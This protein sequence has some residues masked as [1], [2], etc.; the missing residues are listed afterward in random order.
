MKL[1]ALLTAALVALAVPEAALAD[2]TVT[3][4]FLYRDRNFTYNGGFNGIEPTRPVRQA[5]VQV[6][7][8]STGATLAAA[9]TDDTGFVSIDVTGSGQR[10]IL[11]RCQSR[12]RLYGSFRIRVE[13]TSQ[14]LYS[15]STGVFAGWDQNTDLDFGTVISEKIFSGSSQANPFNMLDMCVSGLDYVLAQGAP[16]PS[17]T[18]RMQWPGGSGSFASGF[19]AN[20]ATDDGYD[21]MVQLHEL[22]H[23]LHNMYSDSD[24]PGGSH[25]FGDS[26]QDP[27]LSYGEGWAT[28]FAGAV[29]NWRNIFD[30]AFYMDCNG[31]VAT[32]GIQLRMRMENSSPYISS[33]GGEA[34]EVGVACALWD[35]VDTAS[36]NDGNATDDDPLDGSFVFLNAADGDDMHWQTFTGPVD[37]AANLTIRNHWDAFFNPVDYG[38]HAELETIFANFGINN[39]LDADE[40]NNS[41]GGATPYVGNDTWTPIRTLYFSNATPPAPGAG[42]T[43]HYSFTLQNGEGFEVETRYPNGSSNALTYADPFLRIFR[44]NGTIFATNNDGGTGRNAFINATA[45]A[46]GTWVA[47]VSST[48]SYRRTGSYQLRIFRGGASVTGITPSTI[49]AVSLT[50]QEIVINGSGFNNTTGVTIDGVALAAGVSGEYQVE[51]DGQIRATVPLLTQ[52]G[53]VDVTVTTTTA[54]A[55][56]QIQVDPVSSPLVIAPLGAIQSTGITLTSAANLLDWTWVAVSI[57]NEPTIFPGLFALDIGDNNSQIVIP[58]RPVIGLP[59]HVTK[60]FGPL[61]GLAGIQLYWQSFVLE[62][63][64]MYDPP[65]PSSN[66]S[67]TFILF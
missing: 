9:P 17:G 56:A 39:F 25:V 28:F 53:M 8:N 24:S 55:T 60:T 58:W 20:M 35:L 51:S 15:V 61:S 49:E 54:Q 30:P 26:D 14:V 7:D 18:I 34:T 2:F 21:D 57:F 63:A 23:V 52:L 37:S 64:N 42:D 32:G 36:T 13:T 59:G 5:N 33:T 10:D 1:K 22:G 67:S 31:S 29:R 43:D 12:S 46:S 40:P 6:I 41:T 27:R 19:R 44:P 3:G 38:A 50:P 65:W 48:H 16:N 47:Q 66:V 4:T 11:V 45:D 62:A